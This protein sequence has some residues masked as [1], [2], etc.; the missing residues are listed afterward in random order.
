[1]DAIVPEPGT[2]ARH[3]AAASTALVSRPVSRNPATRAR[4]GQD[5]LAYLDRFRP[6][7]T[8]EVRSRIPPESLKVIDET[9]PL[10]W[11]PLQHDKHNSAATV[12][13]LGEEDAVACWRK[14]LAS[15]L[16]APLFRTIV[17]ATIRVFGLAPA[18]IVRFTPRVWPLV[19]RDFCIPRVIRAEPSTAELL[20]DDLHPDVAQWRPYLVSF[21]AFFLG[22]YE[23][24]SVDGEVA[25][26]LDE[27]RRAARVDFRWTPRGDETE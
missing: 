12:E 22:F 26:E 4:S 11:V 18:P 5:A 17:D 9:P 25:L 21:R 13:V 27:K 8:Q 23:L 1:M 10:G 3:T 24:C 2:K 6:G 14:F 15:H 19:Y 7:L 20:L 16:E